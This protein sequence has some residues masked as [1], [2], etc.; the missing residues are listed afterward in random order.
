MTDSYRFRASAG[1]TQQW[2]HFQFSEDSDSGIAT[3]T[4]TGRTN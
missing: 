3:V 2:Q 1:L 4:W